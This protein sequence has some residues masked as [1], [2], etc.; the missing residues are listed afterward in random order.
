LAAAESGGG[1]GG[2]RP[3]SIAV[4]TGKRARGDS[5][6]WLVGLAPILS[7]PGLIALNALDGLLKFSSPDSIRDSSKAFVIRYHGPPE[8]KFELGHI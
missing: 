4:A 2:A 1:D 3:S 5:C 6:V 7:A 8:T